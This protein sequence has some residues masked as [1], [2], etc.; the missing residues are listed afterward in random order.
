MKYN[1]Y[2]FLNTLGEKGRGLGISYTAEYDPTHDKTIL[3]LFKKTSKGLIRHVYEIVWS[4]V[5]NLSIA[6]DGIFDHFVSL[7][8]NENLP[9]YSAPTKPTNHPSIKN[10][11]FNDPA[12]IVL[13]A[14]GTKTIVKS[15]VNDIYDPEKG[16]AMAIA[17]KCLGNKGNYYETFKKW[18]PKENLDEEM[19]EMSKHMR[20]AADKYSVVGRCLDR[21]SDALSKALEVLIANEEVKPD[22]H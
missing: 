8:E 13:W 1:N 9:K 15:S 17:K 2:I 5:D 11:I 19:S 20:V 21:C 6:L 16:L 4:Y 12:T 7:I 10:V 22:E 18:L 14:D 3:R